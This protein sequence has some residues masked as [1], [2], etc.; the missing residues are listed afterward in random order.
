MTPLLDRLLSSY[1]ALQDLN[2]LSIE[3]AVYTYRQ[4]FEDGFLLA[5]HIAAS[6]PPL[7]R[8][9]IFAARSYI[10]Y[11]GVLASILSGRAYVPIEVKFP[12]TRQREIVRQSGCSY[13]FVDPATEPRLIEISR[14]LDRTAIATKETDLHRLRASARPKPALPTFSDDSAPAY[15]MFTSGTTGIPKGVLVT[16]NNLTSYLDGFANIASVFPGER[17]SQ[18][19][20]L[21][22]DLSV[23]DMLC[24]WTSGGCLCVPS[25]V[26]MIDL[27]GFALRNRLNCWFSVPS[28][29]SFAE[30]MKRTK[31]NQLTD[32]RL[33]L[34]CGEPLPTSIAATWSSVAPNSE[35]W[36]L[37]GPTEA[38]IAVTAHRFNPNAAAAAAVVPLG[39]PWRGSGVG[40]LKGAENIVSSEGT[41]ELVLRGNQI[42]SGYINNEEQNR[43]KF[44]PIKAIDGLLHRWYR[45]GDLVELAAEGDL[46]FLGRI[47]DQVKVQGYRVEL[48]EVEA[49][50]RSAA[51]ATEVAA[52]AWPLSDGGPASSIV[53]FVCSS[54][55]TDRKIVESC[56]QQLPNYM[57]PK[58]IIFVD[59][60]PYNTNGKL[61]RRA[62]IQ[63][64]LEGRPSDQ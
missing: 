57:V 9:G 45:T 17:C 33:S 4:L 41:G 51:Q 59:S 11:V 1:H 12:E 18:F 26:D 5:D 13:V 6:T 50:L 44:I 23:H 54:T 32:L 40:I 60:L 31:P 21:T 39:R 43:T 58:K 24:T 15:V 35:I 16:R 14:V 64:H 42:S 61:D 56:R 48:L 49:A 7:A 27:P 25:A 36:N 28:V 55:A 46:R 20:D 19:F 53:G 30:R 22:F 34:F 62:L 2:A 8:V 38:T 37:Y 47:D 29:V 52:V 10:A 63:R 3:G